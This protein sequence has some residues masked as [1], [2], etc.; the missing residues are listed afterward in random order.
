[1]PL[2]AY[3]SILVYSCAIIGT[4]DLFVL[5]F[6]FWLLI[7]QLCG[8][9]IVGILIGISES[10]HR[11]ISTDFSL[12]VSTPLSSIRAIPLKP[13]V[14]RIRPKIVPTINIFIAA[15][16]LTKTQYDAMTTA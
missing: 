8:D 12:T 10:T 16:Y 13:T 6:L 1:M 7:K 14:A 4:V 5:Y 2:R 3:C 9:L 11:A 15:P